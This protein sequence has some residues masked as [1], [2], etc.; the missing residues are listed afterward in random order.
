MTFA[1]LHRGEWVALFAALC[2]LLV[3]S[4]TWYSTQLGNVAR[5]VESQDTAQGG[6]AGAVDQTLRDE[7]HR[8][9]LSQ[10]RDAWQ[11]NSAGDWIVLVA[12]VAAAA[13]AIG[14][15]FLRADGRTGRFS[16]SPTALAALLGAICAVLL[17][18][19]IID[20]LSEPIGATVELGA[21]LGLGCAAALTL[22]AA[23]SV[24]AQ[25]TSQ[26]EAAQTVERL[27][28]DF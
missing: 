23:V 14:A 25:R 2:L 11:P 24:R 8:V 18:A 15:A 4:G 21:Y 9:A 10:Q 12:C 28:K 27:A 22:G 6:F 16:L 5:Q 3:M 13:S 1:R 26:A 19:Q 20:T 17:M 7:A